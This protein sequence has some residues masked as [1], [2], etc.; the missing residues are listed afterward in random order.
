MINPISGST[1]MSST[2]LGKTS[3]DAAKLQ[4]AAPPVANV[5]AKDEDGTKTDDSK[6]VQKS[7]I[8]ALKIL[9]DRETEQM[10]ASSQKKVNIPALGVMAY[11]NP[12]SLI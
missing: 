4:K 5:K 12:D 1:V 3:L 9:A 10:Q 2:Q 8:Q 6:E 7:S 11:R